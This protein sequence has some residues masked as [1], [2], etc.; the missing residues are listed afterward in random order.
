M[1][2]VVFL[3]VVEREVRIFKW[4]GMAQEH[5]TERIYAI[6]INNCHRVNHI[7]ERLTHLLPSRGN[8][9]VDE[10]LARKREPG[11]EKHG[12]EHC[13]LLTEVVLTRKVSH[14]PPLRKKRLV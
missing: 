8:E 2:R 6:R 5:I 4:V 1:G 12:L 11:G 10:D 9:P 13:G 7:A 14:G 3:N